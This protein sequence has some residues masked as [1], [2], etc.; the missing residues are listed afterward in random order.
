MA[1]TDSMTGL[2]NRRH[3]A[4]VLDQSIAAAKRAGT[5]LSIALMDIDH[6][7]RINDVYGHPIGDEA[8]RHVS[9]L[10]ALTA[11]K[12]DIVARW[13]GEEFLAIFP[14]TT[15]PGH[16]I[17]GERYR[18]R[19]ANAPLTVENKPIEITISIGIATLGAETSDDLLARADK[20]LYRAKERGR[21]RVE[22]ADG[23][24]GEALADSSQKG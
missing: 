20:A 5:P 18:M 10:L 11:R 14:G 17:A 2:F 3:G 6:F 4:L 12:S 19:I 7:K 23:P 24:L 9:E 16:R 15:T 8:I 22:V 13:G 1:C 21:N